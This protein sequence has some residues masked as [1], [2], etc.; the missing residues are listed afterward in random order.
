MRAFDT[1]PDCAAVLNN[2]S[3]PTLSRQVQVYPNP[4]TEKLFLKGPAVQQIE[5]LVLYN[6]Y[7]Q[8]VRQV[9]GPV[10]EASLEGLAPGLYVV[11]VK[12]PEGWVVKRVVKQ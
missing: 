11:Q 4:A 7:G 10:Q 6:A 9:F 3:S 8:A 1:G 5:L 2:T 12:V